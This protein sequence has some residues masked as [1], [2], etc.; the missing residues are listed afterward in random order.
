MHYLAFDVSRDVA[1][2]VLVSVR[3]T[4]KQRFHLPNDQEHLVQTLQDLIKTYPKLLVGVESTALFHMPVVAA[5]SAL[6]LVCNVINPILTKEI[7]KSSIR[8][9]KT[10]REDAVV[11]AKLLIQ[12]EGTPTTISHITNEHKTLVRSANKLLRLRNGLTMHA[13]TVQKRIGMIPTALQNSIT[14]VTEAR[15]TLQ[16]EAIAQ[17]DSEQQNMLTSIPG[18]GSWL[19]TVILS[20]LGDIHRFTSGDA[21]IAYSG[22]DPKVRVSGATLHHT[23]R[24][25]KRG[26]PHLRWALFCAANIARMH[27]PDLKAFY[28]KKRS[29]GKRHGAATCATARKLALRIFAVL[30]RQKPYQCK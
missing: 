16:A 8:K 3:C 2:G 9:R 30:R 17:T 23:G 5:C 19:A 4:V 25:T 7:L 13:R 28:G 12:G 27:D 20:E 1:D 10:D 18:I 22:L 26:S 11:I 15:A 24:L 29:E 6:G 14:A 21:I